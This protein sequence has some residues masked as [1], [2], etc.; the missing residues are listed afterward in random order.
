VYLP[1]ITK[2]KPKRKNV[3]QAAKPG[4]AFLKMRQK[5][6]L[7]IVSIDVHDKTPTCN[8]DHD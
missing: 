3:N 5:P 6:I 8:S 2:S 4:L 1:S 7:V